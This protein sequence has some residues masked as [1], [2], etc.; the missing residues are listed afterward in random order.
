MKKYEFTLF[1]LKQFFLKGKS[2]RSQKQH[3]EE[4]GKTGDEVMIGRERNS[5]YPQMSNDMSH[6]GPGITFPI[7]ANTSGKKKGEYALL[8]EPEAFSPCSKKFKLEYDIHIQESTC[9][10]V[11]MM[12]KEAILEDLYIWID[13]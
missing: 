10:C 1:C 6:S 8:W 3:A 12:Q 4:E 5:S 7:F 9:L 2:G 13:L 11:R